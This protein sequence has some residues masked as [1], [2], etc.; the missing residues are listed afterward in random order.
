LDD[1]AAEG[2]V[3]TVSAPQPLA[4][5]AVIMHFPFSDDGFG[6]QMEREAIYALEDLLRPAVLTAGGEHDGHEFLAGEAVT[7]TYGPDADTLMDA[8]RGCLTVELP[9]GAY[10]TKRYGPA[11]DPNAREERVS[12]TGSGT[13][14]D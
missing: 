14:T 10:A 2:T 4:N 11:T 12:L 8:I 7:F 5:H 9:P 13:T 6:T 1:Q 3:R